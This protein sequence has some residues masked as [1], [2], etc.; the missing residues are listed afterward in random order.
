[1]G[2]KQS[3]R[4]VTAF[5]DADP[6]DWVDGVI[7]KIENFGAFVQVVPG[8][9][10]P[11]AQGLLHI[12]D[13]DE[14]RPRDPGEVLEVGQEGQVRIIGVDEQKGR[15]SLSMKAPKASDP[16]TADEHDAIEVTR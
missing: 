11:T 13:I 4:D 8:D 9:G 2:K 6:S 7:M 15:I 1:M 10:A 14:K 16:A 5:V 3:I 12:T